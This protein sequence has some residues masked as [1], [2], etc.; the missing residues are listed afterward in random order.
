MT[1]KDSGSKKLMAIKLKK[2][3]IIPTITHNLNE[4]SV[5]LFEK[6]F[7]NGIVY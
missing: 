3:M 2:D 1:S 6:I 7:R 4:Y 5:E